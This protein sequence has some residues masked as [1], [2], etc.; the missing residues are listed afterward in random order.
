MALRIQRVPR[1]LNDL[2][3]IFGGET[4]TDLAPQVYGMVD[5]LQFYA[6]SQDVHFSSNDPALAEGGTVTNTIS[7]TNWVVLLD[8]NAT[9]VKTGTMTACWLNMFARKNALASFEYS[10]ENGSM[11]PFGATETGAVTLTWKQTPS[12]RL[13]PPGT[14]LGVRLTVLGTDATANVTLGQHVAILG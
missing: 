8:L 5:L 9:V 11:G 2:L 6:L 10:L 14:Q 7:N 1:G 12:F 13:L 3:S 4:P